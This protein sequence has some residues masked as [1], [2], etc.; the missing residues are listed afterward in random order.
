M[1]VKMLDCLGSRDAHRGDQVA[2]T[3]CKPSRGF[4]YGSGELGITQGIVDVLPWDGK[5]VSPLTGFIGSMK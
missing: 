2:L 3:R 5:D 1:N 4:H